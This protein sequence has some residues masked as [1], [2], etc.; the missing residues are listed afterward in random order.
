[1]I[2]APEQPASAL[3]VL[4]DALAALAEADAPRLERLAALAGEAGA[5]AE[6]HRA[7]REEYAALG[8]LLA[9]TRQNMRLLRGERG[10][11]Y[12]QDRS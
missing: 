5:P 6:E 7:A 10:G 3:V 2:N 11:A 4:R 8:L 9:L 1:M 12:G